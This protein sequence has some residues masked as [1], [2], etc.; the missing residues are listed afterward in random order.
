MKIENNFGEI[1]CGYGDKVIEFGDFSI[2]LVI[3]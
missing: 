1:V 2:V 3:F